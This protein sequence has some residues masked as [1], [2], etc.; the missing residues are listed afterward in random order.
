MIGPFLPDRLGER[1]GSGALESVLTVLAT[2]MLS[3]VT[4]SLGIMVSA[5]TAA[6][7]AVTPRITALLTA[8]KT[9]QRVLSTFLGSFLFSLIGIIA[10]KAGVYSDN[11]RLGLFAVTILIV[12]VIVI[13]ILRWIAHLTVFGLMGDSI[14]KVETA[15]REAR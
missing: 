6:A 1:L 13:A 9:T 10:L 4:F 12:A 8:D 11:N 15:A 3:V 7:D 14:S 2:S 5:F